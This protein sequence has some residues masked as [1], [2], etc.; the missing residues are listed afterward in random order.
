MNA[1]D[2]LKDFKE[3]VDREL[4]I[5][6]DK[7]IKNAQK[8]DIIIANAL[9]YVKEFALSGGKRIRP[10]FMYYGYL[11][12]GGKEREKIIRASI[13]IELVHI[14]LLIHDDIMDRDNTRH[15]IDTVHYKYAKLGKRFF[16][17]GD[18]EHFGC[19]MGIMIG[20]MIGAF[21]NQVI[22]DSK[23]DAELIMKAL[24]RLQSII[25]MTV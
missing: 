23:F 12:A 14:Y 21:G 4:G 17:D 8:H 1:L 6:L 19:S 20:D 5:Y 24:S 22:Y 3:E 16:K 10:A 18:F 2:G 11:A 25:A 9:K 13:S 15:G 7:T